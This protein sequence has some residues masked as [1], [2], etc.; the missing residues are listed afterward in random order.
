[1]DDEVELGRLNGQRS[2]G[3]SPL[4]KYADVY[5]GSELRAANGKR[6]IPRDH[7]ADE[8]RTCYD[9]ASVTNVC[10]SYRLRH[11]RCRAG[12]GFAA[13]QRVAASR[14]IWRSGDG[15]AQFDHRIQ[16]WR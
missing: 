12:T 14:F 1:M 11:A 5:S 2:A 15:G 3:F 6:T 16:T 4:E 7:A 10:C 8:G 9:I 13:A